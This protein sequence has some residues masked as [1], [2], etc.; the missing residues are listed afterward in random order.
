M[1]VTAERAALRPVEVGA[2]TMDYLGP[3][4]RVQLRV[5]ARGRHGV[6]SGWMSP[7]LAARVFLVPVGRRETY[8][9]AV[10]S[11]AGHFEFGGLATGGG[12]RLVFLSD[13]CERPITTP[14]FWV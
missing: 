9:E 6:V 14:P 2:W 1:T 13:Q 11:G 3:G 10:I 5:T 12:Y 4:F 7:A 8:V